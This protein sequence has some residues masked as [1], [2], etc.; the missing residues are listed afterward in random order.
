MLRLSMGSEP[1]PHRRHGGR[2]RAPIT[3]EVVVLA[4][5][6]RRLGRVVPR[7]IVPAAARLGGHAW[8]VFVVIPVAVRPFQAPLWSLLGLE[9]V[10]PDDDTCRQRDLPDL[11][12]VT[13]LPTPVIGDE[14]STL[15]PLA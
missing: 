1:A 13:P 11:I 8:I 12:T 6:R 7:S 10:I 9:R 14:I 5:N 15:I 4:E 3:S 2:A